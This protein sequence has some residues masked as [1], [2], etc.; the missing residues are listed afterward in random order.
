M[1]PNPASN[2]LA[3][4]KTRAWLSWPFSSDFFRRES[5]HVPRSRTSFPAM[6]TSRGRTLQVGRSGNK[7]QTRP[8][9]VGI[10]LSAVCCSA[11]PLFLSTHASLHS[12]TAL[13]HTSLAF[14]LGSSHFVRQDSLGF[15]GFWHRKSLG[16]DE[17]QDMSLGMDTALSSSSSL[18][19]STLFVISYLLTSVSPTVPCHCHA[20]LRR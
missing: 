15:S 11:R 6:P 12:Q 2:C 5:R 20:G 9:K 14:L 13:P 17:C 19:T 7:H 1:H 8:W 18:P 4:N 10:L 3:S 16:T